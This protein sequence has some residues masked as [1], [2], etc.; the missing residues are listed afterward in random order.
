MKPRLAVQRRSAY[1]DRLREYK[2]FVDGVHVGAVEN[3]GTF[4]CS[5]Q[6]GLHELVLRIDWQTTVPTKFQVADDERISFRCGS[7]L[8]GGRLLFGAALALIPHEWIW[9]ERTSSSLLSESELLQGLE[10]AITSRETEQAVGVALAAFE[11]GLLAAEP[12]LIQLL[13]K[14]DEQVQ[15]A[16]ILALSAVGSGDSMTALRRIVERAVAK[17][18]VLAA[19]RASLMAIHSRLGIPDEGAL[20]L[21]DLGPGGELA[22][23]TGGGLTTGDGE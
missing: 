18:G 22:L 13:A 16:A 1:A 14:D 21:A 20:A 2:V 19:T 10:A 9:L 17:P 3:G 23:D 4:D 7:K 5:V 6:P 12:W 11:K 15:R 8:T